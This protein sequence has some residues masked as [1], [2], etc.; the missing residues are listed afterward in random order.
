MNPPQKFED[1]FPSYDIRASRNHS[2]TLSAIRS[3]D[4]LYLGADIELVVD[5]L[6]TEGEVCVVLLLVPLYQVI[7][8][9]YYWDEPNVKKVRVRAIGNSSMD[10]QQL[11]LNWYAE[12]AE[13]YL[14]KKP[15]DLTPWKKQRNN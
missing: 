1:V 14:L 12:N 8:P 11:V 5:G 4:N 2:R 7:S 6:E 15:T 13:T 10:V 9:E 3:F